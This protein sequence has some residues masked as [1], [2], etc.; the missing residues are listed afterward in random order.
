[1]EQLSSLFQ[2]I[3]ELSIYLKT[4]TFEKSNNDNHHIQIVKN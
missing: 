4:D 1:M 2:K 3:G